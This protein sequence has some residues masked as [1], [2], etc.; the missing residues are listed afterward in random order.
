MIHRQI[1]PLQIG[2]RV[3]REQAPGG[4][5]HRDHLLRREALLPEKPLYIGCVDGVQIRVL[6]DTGSLPLLP[7]RSAEARGAANSVTVGPDVG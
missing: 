4:D 6:Q 3:L 1:H 7:Q 2:L 5:I